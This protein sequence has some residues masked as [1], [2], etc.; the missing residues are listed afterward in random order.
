M[1]IGSPDKTARLEQ[2]R[3]W[4]RA[5]VWS[6]FR[7]DDEV[8]TDVLDAVRAE[9]KDRAEAERLADEYVADAQARHREAAATWP[10]RTD[11]DRFE[12]AVTELEGAGV[13]VLQAVE[14]HWAANDE[15]RN[16]TEVGL[17]PRGIAWF[18]HSDVWHAVE[19]GMLEVNLWHGDSANVAEGEDLLDFVVET[20]ERHRL[21]AHFDEGRIEV[22]MHW[23]CRPG[24][25]RP[26]P[27]DADGGGGIS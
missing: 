2:L 23:Q 14:D 8:R 24:S 10:H 9:V 11:V 18:T 21:P 4:T 12:D 17:Q 5:Q 7:S 22:T 3:D 26:G 6:G 19:H 15:L 1:A 25:G 13:V 16:R 20:L 27:V